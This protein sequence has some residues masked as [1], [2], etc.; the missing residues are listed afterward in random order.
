MAIYVQNWTRLQKF[1]KSRIW[2]KR[3]DFVCNGKMLANKNSKY[4]QSSKVISRHGR[5]TTKQAIS[6]R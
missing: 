4:R 1:C 6:L 2:Q 3:K 5:I